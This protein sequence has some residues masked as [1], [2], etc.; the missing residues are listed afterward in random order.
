MTWGY[1]TLPGDQV[2]VPM[3]SSSVGPNITIFLH[4]D[5]ITKKTYIELWSVVTQRLRRYRY[6]ILTDRF[7]SKPAERFEWIHFKYKKKTKFL[8]LK[9]KKIYR[10]VV[11]ITWGTVK[12]VALCLNKHLKSQC[13][14]KTI[15]FYV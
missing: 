4:D 14:H 3:N 6:Q 8:L 10:F 11:V 1:K 12:R 13:M 5:N 15:Q 7:I 2:C 9:K